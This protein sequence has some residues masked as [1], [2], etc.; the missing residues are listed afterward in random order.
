MR[1]AVDEQRHEISLV[2]DPQSPARHS[3]GH[4]LSDHRVECVEAID[5]V[6]HTPILL[7][8]TDIPSPN[9]T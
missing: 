3:L 7:R 5:E 4:D 2:G 9:S 1:P 8:A 6:F